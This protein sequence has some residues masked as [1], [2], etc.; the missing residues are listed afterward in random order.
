MIVA[1]ELAAAIAVLSFGLMRKA[2][3][4]SDAKRP[5]EFRP[6]WWD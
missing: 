2:R 1:L 5:F 4:G 6:D 3:R